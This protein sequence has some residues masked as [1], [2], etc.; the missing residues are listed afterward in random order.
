MMPPT[1]LVV[2]APIATEMTFHEAL[3]ALREANPRTEADRARVQAAEADVVGAEVA[4]NPTFSYDG[5]RLSSGT[6]TGAAD[7]DQWTLEWPVLIFG[8][9]GARRSAATSGVRAAV[10][11]VG[12]GFAERALALRKAFGSLWVQQERVTTLEEASRDLTRVASIVSGRHEAGDASPYDALRVE[13]EA[14]TLTAQLGDARADLADAQGRVARILGRPGMLAHAAG[15]VVAD[16][17]ARVDPDGAWEEAKAH[18]PG[19]DAARREEDAAV[20]S[21]RAARRERYPVP[22]LTAGVE[23]TRDA[24]SH[25]ALVGVAIPLPVLDRN[26]GG[27]ARARA[28]AEEASL[29]RLASEAEWHADLLAALAVD[30]ERRAAVAEIESGVAARLPELRSM[31][32]SAYREGRGGILDFLDALR[33]LTA[34]R[35]TRLDALEAEAHADA[36]LLFLLGRV[37]DDQ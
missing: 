20:A 30:A 32:E 28:A 2:A 31:A 9:R 11:E 5:T 37:E 19:L 13:T 26:Q 8:Q 29:D 25:S 21:E 3:A 23:N 17:L 16:A 27:V 34:S 15:S 6:N 4:P 7:V 35:L 1:C 14:R 36:D 12:A 33:T 24:A 18:A 22:S 10:A